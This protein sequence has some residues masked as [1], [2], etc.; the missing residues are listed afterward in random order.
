[1]EKPTNQT[2]SDSSASQAVPGHRKVVGCA[3]PGISI[4]LVIA[5][6]FIAWYFQ[7]P[8]T[9]VA[10]KYLAN[11]GVAADELELV[12]FEDH[13]FVPVFPFPKDASAE[14][15]AK[16]ADRPKNFEVKL[17][18]TVYFLPWYATGFRE[19]VEK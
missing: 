2:N 10:R 17:S 16:G 1:M 19:K 14:F 12:G 15:R 6:S 18:R 5:A 4:C 11:Q 3:F 8:P 13:G 7:S 9:A